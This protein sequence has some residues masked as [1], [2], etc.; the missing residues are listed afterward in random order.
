MLSEWAI[1][2]DYIVEV[3]LTILD[4]QK[5]DL[6]KA[7]SNLDLSSND[8]I[9][10][11]YLCADILDYPNDDYKEKLKELEDLT[12]TKCNSQEVVL[13]DL[14]AEYIQIFSI[15]STKLKCVP[16]ASWWIDGKM[17][18]KTLS[19]I[20][21]FYNRCGYE[22]DAKSMKKPADNLSSMVSFIAILA[23]DGK[24]EEIKEFAKFLTWIDDF[25]SSLQSATQIKT[26]GYAIEVSKQIISSFKGKL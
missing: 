25:A 16:Y 17:S 3:W 23:E 19:K 14:Q 24:E 20:L 6:S 22:F 12:N 15:N 18:G 4:G 5:E 11:L 2:Q 9:S 8:K 21:D 1:N 10:A 7:T 26:F 13:D